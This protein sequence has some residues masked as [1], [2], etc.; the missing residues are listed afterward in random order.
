MAIFLL[1]LYA[2]LF[3]GLEISVMVNGDIYDFPW[4]TF[5]IVWCS[6][7]CFITEY[8][9]N[10]KGIKNGGLWGFFLSIIGVIIVG[11]L[12]NE[13]DKKIEIVNS[14][15]ENSDTIKNIKSY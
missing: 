9:G 13:N 1:S 8:I 11:F 5:T 3:L 7:W 12:P 10:K 6:I 4:M 2:I 14:V 15:T